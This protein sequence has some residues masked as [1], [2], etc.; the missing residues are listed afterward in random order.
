MSTTVDPQ[1]PAPPRPVPAPDVS[2]RN[3]ALGALVL[4]LVIFF[5]GLWLQGG[6]PGG[7]KAVA[8]TVYFPAQTPVA[9]GTRLTF[10]G[11]QVG[12]V[13]SVAT[14]QVGMQVTVLS[15]RVPEVPEVA[16]LLVGRSATLGNGAVLTLRDAKQVVI[17][18]N[19]GTLTADR[20]DAR[21]WTLRA[22]GAAP[23]ITRNGRVILTKPGDA[24]PL[25]PGDRL[26]FGTAADAMRVIWGDVDY[27]TR[28]SVQVRPRDFDA[29]ARGAGLPDSAGTLGPGT[30]VAL[31]SG[32]GHPRAELELRP[33][34]YHGPADVRVAPAGAPRELV[35]AAS[36]DPLATLTEIAGFVGSPTGLRQAPDNRAEAAFADANLILANAADVS[37]QLSDAGK[38]RDSGVLVRLALDDANQQRLAA[39]LSSGE[40]LKTATGNLAAASQ[41]LR[42][43]TERGVLL[44]QL[45]G[46]GYGSLQAA[47]DNARGAAGNARQLTASVARDTAKLSAAI[48]NVQRLSAHVAGDTSRIDTTLANVN[49]IAGNLAPIVRKARKPGLIAAAAAVGLGIL[50]GIRSLVH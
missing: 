31:L 19:R 47:I 3:V 11:S 16:T 32:F 12:S 21:E 42:D 34:L 7:G 2:W 41:A 38:G 44:H 23:G 5:G 4:L 40:N 24:E 18:W 26:G 46:G 35:P 15:S 1:A 50:N 28:A 14:A 48:D 10:R 33:S 43:T 45:L 6:M 39:L 25:H 27:L 36:A 8:Y 29:A 37:K 22:S 13:D 49:G 20:A 30:A 17:T 9:P